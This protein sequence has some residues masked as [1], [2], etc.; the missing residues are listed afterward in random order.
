LLDTLEVSPGHRKFIEALKVHPEKHLVLEPGL[1]L[2]PD[3]VLYIHYLPDEAGWAHAMQIHPDGSADV[4]RHRPDQL[5]H[6][7]RWLAR[8]PDED[9]IGFEPA[10]AEVDGYTAEKKKGNVRQLGPGSVFH[11]DMQVGMLSPQEAVM[12]AAAI[13]KII[14]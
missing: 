4:V 10:T 12:E 11:C 5:D 3:V 9:A 13:Q 2:F 6:G 14:S 1:P 8:T 7:I